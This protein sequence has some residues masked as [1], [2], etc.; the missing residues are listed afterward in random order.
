MTSETLNEAQLIAL[1]EK[2][3]AAVDHKNVAD[4]SPTKPGA[5]KSLGKWHTWWEKFDG[6]LSQTTRAAEIGLNYIY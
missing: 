2:Y 6:Y 4:E 1:V 3:F 5:L